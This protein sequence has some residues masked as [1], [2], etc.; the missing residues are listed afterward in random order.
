MWCVYIYIIYLYL[1]LYL[2]IYQVIYLDMLYRSI[3]LSI[4]LSV[5]LSFYI[6]TFFVLGFRHVNWEVPLGIYLDVYI[7]KY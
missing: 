4:Y 2:P 5:C 3:C 6:Y 7:Y 1:Y